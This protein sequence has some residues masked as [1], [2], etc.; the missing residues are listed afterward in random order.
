MRY[1]EGQDL[2][3]LIQQEGKLAPEQALRILR[4]VADALD[5]A[6]AHGLVHRDVKPGNILLADRRARL[7][8]RLRPHPPRRR[9]RQPDR[10]RRACRLDRLR[11]PRTDRRTRRR[12]PRRRLLPRLRHLRMPHRQRPLPARLTDGKALRAPPGT[13]TR[14]EHHQPCA[15]QRNSTPHSNRVSPKTQPPATRPHGTRLRRRRSTRH[16]P[17][18]SEEP[19]TT[20]NPH[21]PRRHSTRSTRRTRRRP[22]SDTWRQRARPRS[23]YFPST[24]DS[25]VAYRPRLELADRCR[26]R[27]LA[28]SHCRR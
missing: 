15:P 21:P 3:Q 9:R 26:P 7:P 4:P 11:R 10:S 14:P 1:V 8:L 28:H 18:S 16:R 17:G 23:R 12:R 25:V 2:R 27:R 24:G 5:Y 20:A 6:H 19:T 13:R 22:R